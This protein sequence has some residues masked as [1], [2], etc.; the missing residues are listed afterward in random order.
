MSILGIAIAALIVGGTG[1]FI[2]VF[3]GVAENKFAVETDEREDAI[4]EVL[5]GNNCGGCG[6]AGCSGLATAIVA[7]EAETSAC[8]VGGTPVT[9]QI[10][11]IMGQETKE[12]VREVAFVKCGGTSEK[13][14][15][16]YEYYGTKNCTTMKFVQADGP[17]GCKYGCYGYGTCVDVCQFDAINIIDGVAVVDKEQCKACKACIKACPKNIIELVPYTQK[18]IV[19][20]VSENKGKDVMA[21]CSAGCIGCKLCEKA[22][23]VTAI[24]VENNIA[25]IDYERCTNCGVCKEKCPKKCIG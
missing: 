14:K 13:A 21:V 2:G 19:L 25:H 17:K 16:E 11:K 4:L 23:E 24:K 9:V 15:Q 7:G 3:L 6:Y 1:L 20:C 12:K 8:P 10:N 18:Q 5:P 22:C